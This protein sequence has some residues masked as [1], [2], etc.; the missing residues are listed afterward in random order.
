MADFWALQTPIC[1]LYFIISS[2]EEKRNKNGVILVEKSVSFK[3]LE[4]HWSHPHCRDVAPT[5]ISGPSEQK[6]RCYLAWN[7]CTALKSL[8]AARLQCGAARKETAVASIVF[9]ASSLF[10]VLPL[11]SLGYLLAAC[12]IFLG[13]AR[14]D[15]CEE[16]KARFN[17][18]QQQK[19][20]KAHPSGAFKEGKVWFAK[21]VKNSN[22][23]T[24]SCGQGTADE[25]E[26]RCKISAGKYQKRIFN[27][28]M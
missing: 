16:A 19:I 3:K 6:S 2:A 5:E 13:G 8:R 17:A 4:Q 21:N 23:M 18:N 9:E 12:R 10:W 26:W 24:K 11:P 20:A 14:C 15:G 28:I 7:L 27:Q 25:R 22:W 1:S